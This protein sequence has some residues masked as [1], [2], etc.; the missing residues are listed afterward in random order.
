M[1]RKGGKKITRVL[2]KGPPWKE[3]KKEVLKFFKRVLLLV[4]IPKGR[5]FGP[6]P[7]SSQKELRFP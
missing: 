2:F 7:I 5:N 4:R 6:Q 3:F 1:F